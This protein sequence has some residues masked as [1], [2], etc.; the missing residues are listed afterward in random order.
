MKLSILKLVA[1]VF[2]AVASLGTVA[3]AEDAGAAPETFE[4]QARASVPWIRR[5]PT[6][7]AAAAPSRRGAR[8]LS[9]RAARPERRPDARAPRAPS[10]R[11][12]G[13]TFYPRHR[14]R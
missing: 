6:A 5:S 1:L 4:F 12:P 3:Y 8:G 7:R 2:G 9:G 11:A 13:P 14:P 10:E